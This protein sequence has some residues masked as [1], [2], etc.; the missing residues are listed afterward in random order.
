[1]CAYNSS[2]AYHARIRLKAILSHSARVK[3]ILIAVGLVQPVLEALRGLL[4]RSD[5]AALYTCAC[6][7]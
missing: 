5:G 7:S 2:S 4:G 1:M 3:V 6:A